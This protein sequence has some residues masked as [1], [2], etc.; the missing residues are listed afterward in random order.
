MH[1]ETFT[2]YRHL[3]VGLLC[4]AA[5]QNVCAAPQLAAT[6]PM[7]WNSW[8]AYGTTVTE[9]QVKANA[10]AMADKLIRFGWQYVVVDIQWYAAA[11]AG[12][13]YRPGEALSVDEYG[14][15]IPAVNRFPSAAGGKGFRPLADYI[16]GKGLKFGIHI[17]RGIPRQVVDRN[18]PIKGT[19]YHAA[20]VADQQNGCGWNPDM[21]GVDTSKP[22]S[23]EYYDSLIELYTSWGV[24]FIKAD[25]KGSHQY[26]PAEIRALS[27]AIA[28]SPRPILLSVSPGP[29]A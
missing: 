4:V 5:T 12:H 11:A 9:A 10:D 26:Q 19:A 17:M 6:P 16:H 24:D 18:L 21:W 27:R 1:S 7:G 2:F 13:D 22:G 14:R 8:D 23:Q 3:A 15:L 25:D 20:D 28:K 29:A